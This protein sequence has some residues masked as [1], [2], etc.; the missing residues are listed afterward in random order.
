MQSNDSSSSDDVGWPDLT[1]SDPDELSRI[2]SRNFMQHMLLTTAFFG[3]VGNAAL[4]AKMTI[5]V[6]KTHFFQHSIS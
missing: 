5:S 2:R 3:L 4:V 1:Q 6:L